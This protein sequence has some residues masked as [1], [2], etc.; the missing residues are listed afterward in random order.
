M[1]ARRL[2]HVENIALQDSA[3]N[4]LNKL[5]R[6][7]AAQIEALKRYRSSGEQNVRVTHQHVSVSAKQAI[8]GIHQGGGGIHENTSQPHALEETSTSGTLNAT[9]ATVLGHEQEV[10]MPLPG[11]SSEG[12]VSLPNARGMGRSAEGKS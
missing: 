7:F 12:V 3:S 8:V 1:A 2:N 10:R 4:M 9:G 6:T 11:S 5:S